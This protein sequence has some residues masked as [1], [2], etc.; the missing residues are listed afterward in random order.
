MIKS[1]TNKEENGDSLNSNK[2]F[3]SLT[4]LGDLSNDSKSRFALQEFNYS[5]SNVSKKKCKSRKNLL[6]F[7][8]LPSS[9]FDGGNEVYQPINYNNNFYNISPNVYSS[10][11]LSK[12]QISQTMKS[13]EK[14]LQQKI[15]NISLQIE[16]ESNIIGVQNNNNNNFKFS[17][18]IMQ[19][20]N[21]D[22]KDNTLNFSPQH[23]KK[24]LNTPSNRKSYFKIEDRTD[25]S[26][27]PKKNNMKNNMTYKKKFTRKYTISK[28]KFRK[29]LKKKLIY[30]SFDS[31]EEDELEGIFFSPDN[32]F[33][34]FIDL[35][36]ALSSLFS[37]IYTPYYISNIK[38]FCIKQPKIFMYIYNFIDIL[39]IV[40]LIL[41]FF[42][43]HQNFEFQIIKNNKEIVKHYLF[44][45]FFLD[46]LEAIPFFSYISDKCD[47]FSINNYESYNIKGTHLLLILCCYIKILK[48]FKIIDIKK[49]SVYNK[50][51]HKISKNDLLEKL[52]S[53]I[54][55][56]L[57]CT[58]GFYFFIS[59]HI[60][61]GRSS[62]PNW[63]V[64]S[65]FEDEPLY[66]LYLLSLYYLITTMTTVGY[67][68]I[69]C[70]STLREFFFQLV[71]LSAGISVY[72][73]I[74]SNIGNYVK[75]E[76]NA[77]I[78]FDKDEAILEEIRILY[79]NMPFTLYK[80]IY[81]HLGMRKIRQRQLDSNILINSLPHSLKNEI[82]FSMHKSTI[83][84]FKIFKGNHN[85]DFTIRLLTNFI[86]LIS[87]K[88]AFLIHEG[89]LINNIIF[90]Q[91]GRLSLE[92]CIDIEQPF[93]SVKQYIKKNF[94]DIFEDVVIVSDY[95]TSF[96]ASRLNENNY[97]NIFNKAKDELDTV[98]KDQNKTD[99]SL[100]ESMM[101]KEI[102]KWDFGGDIM[103]DS[104]YNL[105]FLNI[106]SVSKNESFGDVY[107]F[108]CKPSP[109]SLRVK[110]KIA[111]LFLLRRID[112]SDISFRYPNIWSKF[113]KK[114]YKNMLSIKALTIKK[115]KYY[116][117][118]IGI[119]YVPNKTKTIIKNEKLDLS[120]DEHEHEHEEENK[121]ETIIK[122]VLPKIIVS[123]VD[124]GQEQE[125]DKKVGSNFNLGSLFN[126]KD[127]NSNLLNN[128]KNIESIKYISFG[129][130]S[131]RN[132]KYIDKNYR[133]C[134]N[135]RK[136][137]MEGGEPTIIDKKLN[138]QFQRNKLQFSK[139]YSNY[140]NTNIESLSTKNI[141][142]TKTIKD[143]R[144]EYLE[145]LNRKIKK[146]KTS[147][148]Y[149]KDL[150]IKLKNTIEKNSFKS[151]QSIKEKNINEL[152]DIKS[153]NSEKI[154]NINININFNNNNVILDKP[155]IN[156]SKSSINS[157]SNTNSSSSSYSNKF[158][159][160]SQ[161]NLTILPKY[162]N[163]DSFTS[164]EYSKNR[165]LRQTTQKFVQFYLSLFKKTTKE[166]YF[167]SNL[168]NIY[169]LKSTSV[170]NGI[171]ISPSL[172]SG[173]KKLNQ[174][175]KNTL[176]DSIN[177]C[178]SKKSFN[179]LNEGQYLI[180][181]DKYNN[182]FNIFG[183]NIIKQRFSVP[184]FED[185]LS[186]EFKSKDIKDNY[187]FQ[188]ENSDKE[189]YKSN[190][191]KDEKLLY[192]DYGNNSKE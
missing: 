127:I 107:M 102:G 37:M 178:F 55:Y 141:K 66:S 155:E 46:L 121:N 172:S 33:I 90:V 28:R 120:D 184:N 130:E 34:I 137:N 41:G 79:P 105:Q 176:N 106:I 160:S 67:G 23:K 159:I 44:T 153:Y 136:M 69:V 134:Y 65:G 128:N 32:Y 31:E 166:K 2:K 51:R 99:S 7:K 78:R 27:S 21:I 24:G 4:N 61:I 89:Q 138:T 35:L 45:Q 20:M 119:H 49:N 98:L 71:L 182:S 129:K 1:L 101:I 3:I 73:W 144:K 25:K 16:K 57:L 5:Y 111:E 108:L 11:H 179:P 142:R 81:R 14:D 85:T 169:P 109:L 133:S 114:S 40:D 117:K 36:V 161:T 156:I 19:K 157:N 17:T 151:I 124:E 122:S 59:M 113:F 118:N 168:S 103:E 88:N 26:G 135:E 9:N 146:L 112:A 191:I 74:V 15:I 54:L 38:S 29:L 43:G 183:K 68:N 174:E 164:G 60:F 8:R 84:N 125:Q 186:N 189:K 86:P 75:N 96:D 173:K 42:R 154:N 100:N 10:T 13:I 177:K 58:F 185:I 126:S 83:K 158:I 48:F 123:N 93:K 95:D 94:C 77:S 30:D 82:L 149:Y 97:K 147:K 187:D 140:K 6:K 47:K 52:F 181:F 192:Y 116:W 188:N 87:K 165:N 145:K 64:N 143:I 180:I 132:F 62:Y 70:A 148:K 50:I 91:E 22:G 110:S 162:K 63:I 104:N 115:I 170:D 80:N 152:N 56:F 139:F 39:Y 171:N 53:F 167:E 72:S 76:S 190:E 175:N 12:N 92:A 150:C 131:T 18:M 163:L